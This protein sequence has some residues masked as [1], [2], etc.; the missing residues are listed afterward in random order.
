MPT[1][2]TVTPPTTTPPIMIYDKS[3]TDFSSNGIHCLYPT[4][5]EVEMELNKAPTL[6][7]EHPIDE[8]GVW[9]D[10]KLSSIICVPIRYRDQMRYQPFRI[11]AITKSRQSNSMSITIDAR[12]IFYDLN[13]DLVQHVDLGLTSVSCENALDAAFENVYRPAGSTDRIASDNFSYSSSISSV[14][15]VQFDNISLTQAIDKIMQQSTQATIIGAAEL[16]VDGF[17]FSI[18]HRMEGALDDAFNIA[19][20]VNLSGISATY[21]NDNRA[22]GMYIEGASAYISNPIEPVNKESLELAYDK[23]VSTSLSIPEFVY[24]AAQKQRYILEFVAKMRAVEASFDVSIVDIPNLDEYKDIKN[25]ATLEVGDTGTITDT[26]LEI[27]TTQKIIKKKYDAVK[28]ITVSV[29]LGDAK[30]SILY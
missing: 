18:E 16:Y 12:H 19:V 5:A 14:L 8:R 7:M 10:I 24:S 2:T 22:N 21:S 28:H 3:T 6:R 11:F 17:Y 20:G 29:G 27:Q 26:Q 23:V 25:L 4:T 9:K 30:S 1:Y 13:Y 15:N